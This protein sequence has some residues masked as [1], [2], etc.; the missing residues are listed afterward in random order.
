M[1][2]T[3]YIDGYNVPIEKFKV[4]ILNLNR[5]LNHWLQLT[6]ARFHKLRNSMDIGIRCAKYHRVK[7]EL[8]R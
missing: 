4:S 2:N 8:N 7:V 6:F 3:V 1:H 5:D